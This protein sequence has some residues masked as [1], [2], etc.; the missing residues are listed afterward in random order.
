MCDRLQMGST[1]TGDARKTD[2][3]KEVIG[4]DGF[5]QKVTGNKTMT[6]TGQ[7]MDHKN[8]PT[9]FTLKVRGGAKLTVE[10]RKPEKGH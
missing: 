1:R 5:N 4:F 10:E 6:L 9:V 2:S 7:R 8:I 3:A